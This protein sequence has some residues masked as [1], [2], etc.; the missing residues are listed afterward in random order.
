MIIDQQVDIG[1]V[2]LQGDL[3]EKNPDQDGDIDGKHQTPGAFQHTQIHSAPE[4]GGEIR[5]EL[6]HAR[7]TARHYYSRCR[8]GEGRDP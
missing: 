2:G 8:P 1:N 3:V 5:R 6:S 4:N 7:S